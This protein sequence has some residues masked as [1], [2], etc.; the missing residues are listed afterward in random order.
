MQLRPPLRSDGR[1]RGAG[2]EKNI[3]PERSNDAGVNSFFKAGWNRFYLKCYANG[4]SHLKLLCPQ[5]V[6]LLP[7]IP[8]IKAAMVP[9]LPPGAKI[10]P[11]RAPCADSLR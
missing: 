3:V 11:Y 1:P 7:R 8:S 2:A 4:H 5:T 9:D 10:N 6:T